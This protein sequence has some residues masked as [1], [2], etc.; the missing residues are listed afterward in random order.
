[1]R[2]ATHFNIRTLERKTPIRHSDLSAVSFEFQAPVGEN[3]GVQPRQE[4]KQ[5]EVSEKQLAFFDYFS[6]TVQRQGG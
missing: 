3:T 4:S 2:Q 5:K 1:L 6:Y